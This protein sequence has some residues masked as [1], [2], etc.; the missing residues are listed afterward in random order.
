[1]S[2]RLVQGNFNSLTPDSFNIIIGEG[3]ADNLGV[4][5][6]DQVIMYTPQL[7][8][9]PLGIYPRLKQFTI[10]GIFHI[11]ENPSMD[12]GLA[13]INM[14]DAQ[15]LYQL[16]NAVVGLR[17]KVSDLY[18]APAVANE[19]QGILPV[20]FTVTNWTQEYGTFFKAMR[21]EKTM[22]FLLLVF[23]IAVAAFNL[24][25]S[26]V[27]AVNDKQSDIAILRTFGATPRT[28]MATFM[29]QGVLLGL[30]GTLLG[31]IGGVILAYNVG[32]VVD[33]IQK[34]FHVEFISSAVYFINYLPSR[35]EWSDVR[36]V[37]TIAM[38]LS[39]LATI[40][41]A[42]QAS[43]TQPAEALRYE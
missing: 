12:S 43:R 27:M 14:R 18:A 16:N 13:F 9:S 5:V 37:C 31:T 34:V 32:A 10:T 19:L 15:K 42:W 35:L 36:Q 30:V 28:I 1:M 7:N 4:G 2:T 8:A 25:S 29:V 26:L 6:G 33:F 38:V 20:D 17:L 23:I 11:E 39:L 22:I 21:M 3:L 24:V 40:Y 41:P